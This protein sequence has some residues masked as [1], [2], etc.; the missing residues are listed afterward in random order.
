MHLED[1]SEEELNEIANEVLALLSERGI[2]CPGCLI[3]FFY[4]VS[5]LVQTRELAKH[6][7]N[8]NN[9]ELH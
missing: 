1:K 9:H 6:S 4:S 5:N 3:G 7:G 8:E 2:N